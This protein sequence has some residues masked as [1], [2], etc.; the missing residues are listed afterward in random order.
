MR[1]KRRVWA[2]AAVATAA[3]AGVLVFQGVTGTDGADGGVD[4]KSAPARVDVHEN[5]LKVSADGTTADLTQ[6]EAAPFS[7]LGVTWTDP[8]AKVSG[9]VEARTRS[10]ATGEWTGWLP[11]ATDV[12]GRTET[13]QPGVRGTTE[14]RW[15]GASNGVEVR[16]TS[17][18]TSSAG[19]PAGLRLDTVDPGTSGF[20]A[21]T[22]AYA[23]D[24]KEGLTEDGESE[25][26]T[27]ADTAS[28]PETPE[29]PEPTATGDT[30][31]SGGLTGSDSG[32]PTATPT[33]T[34]TTAA[35][36]TPAPTATTPSPTTPAP[37]ATTASPSPT[38]TPGPVSTMPKPPIVG[39]AGWG[40]DESLNDEAP[41]YTTSVK[42]VFVHH[43]AQTNDY[44]C[45]DSPAIMRSLHAFHVRSNGWKDL[46]YNFI[47]DKCGTIFEG[48]K[49][50]VDK[51][52]FGAHT[53][54]FNRETAGIAVIGMYTDTKAATAA[55]TA[56]ARL[57]AWKLGQYK[58]DPAGKTTLVAGATQKSGTG[59]SYTAGETYTF[60]QISGHRDGF[61]TEC[62]GTALYGQLG[63]IRTAAAGPVTGLAVSSVTGSSTSGSTTYTQ[64]GVKVAWTAT[65]PSALISRYEL[66]VD[67]KV[68]ATTNGSTTSATAT[69]ALGTHK[70]QVRATHAS[71][72][73]SAPSAAATV[74][75]E[76][77]APAFTTKPSLALSAGTVNTTAVPVTLKWKAADGIALKEVRLT[78]PAA[79][80]YPAT[81][82]SAAQTAKP[83]V[84]TTWKM[85]AYDRAG[86]TAAA[87]V[88]GTPVILQET[89]TTRTGTWT[90]KSS[91]SYLGG[92]SYS[93]SAKNA[94]MTWTFTGRSAAL[95]V[96][97]AS[98]SGQVYVYV[99]GKKTATVDLKSTTTKYR[100][101]IWTTTWPAAAKHTVK[102][103][104]VG[105]SGRPAITTDGLV[106]L[107]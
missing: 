5:E 80:T 22:A 47:V 98:T 71:G 63:A 45:A 27:P 41:E 76:K 40:A 65:T 18:G 105:T 74:V 30:S 101:A 31:G 4:A 1:S 87:S 107:K 93:S 103:V 69:L 21:E 70:V 66:L 96:S 61:N 82:T 56:V 33:A 7:L 25:E 57:A 38:L 81:T 8:A 97:R 32:E 94:S 52:V 44:S 62:P 75:A 84:P 79:K 102:L 67:G 92:K 3:V 49:G 15:V 17:R 10:V 29:T 95:V 88:I 72:K 35:P 99:D 73:V 34:P 53:Y 91:T 36:T 48:R 26:P 55:T 43:T 6:K 89:S 90:A 59:I 16:V 28:A 64:S 42:A 13:G 37:S 9:T 104:V 77:T 78:A 83:G 68:V 85:T 12:D 50:G 106:Y 23:Q 39:R 14:P 24:V 46:G 86:N 51:P 11:L 60:N 54:G 2:T 20:D 58:G 100:D 19:L